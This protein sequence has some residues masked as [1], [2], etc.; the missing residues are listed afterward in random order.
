MGIF[1][2]NSTTNAA[3][4]CQV[5]GAPLEP[6]CAFCT[7]CG[8]P[9]TAPSA[10]P[11][12]GGFGTAGVCQTCGAPLEPDCAFCT[13]CGAPVSAPAPSPTPSYE[14][15]T[16]LNQNT[17]PVCGAALEPDC[18]FCT[19]CGTP[20][21]AS[22]APSPAPSYEDTTILNQNTCP[23]CGAVLEP[24]AAFCT[25]CGYNL[26][27]SAPVETPD[28]SRLVLCNPKCPNCGQYVRYPYETTCPNCGTKIRSTEKSDS[29]SAPPVPEEEPK[30]S[31]KVCPNCNSYVDAD[32]A[33]CP[34]CSAVLDQNLDRC[35]RCGGIINA[36]FCSVCG[37]RVG[38]ESAA[39]SDSYR[40]STENQTESGRVIKKIVLRPDERPVSPA[41]EQAKRNFKS[42]SD[43]D[44]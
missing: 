9:V 34:N 10:P 15:T 21:S 4:C 37:C 25:S 19:S 32:A 36:G 11:M 17:C 35:P 40:K 26:S 2:K 42:P 27:G 38:E 8:A 28:Y 20:V 12:G 31:F 1:S 39:H 6:D 41:V 7:A 30:P 22:P 33:F 14:D 23:G 16:I 24:D 13:A 29:V 18:A 5:C 43:F 44:V 3:G